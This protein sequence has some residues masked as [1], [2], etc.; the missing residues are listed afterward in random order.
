[1]TRHWKKHRIF[2]LNKLH[3]L[4]LDNNMV[5]WEKSYYNHTFIEDLKEHDNNE[6]FIDL[7]IN[8]SK[9]IDVE[10]LVNV[11]GI[12]FEDKEMYLNTYMSLVTES[13]FFQEDSDFHTGF[14]SE[15]IWKP[16]GHCQPFILA[17][18]SQS[19]KHIKESYGFKTFH[20]YI[21]ESYD[22]ELNDIK[23]IKMIETE[24]EKFSKKTKSE[25]ILFLENVKDICLHNQDLFLK[26]DE[27]NHTKNL[28]N[29]LTFL[30]GL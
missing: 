6:E 10:D 26:Y 16:V 20:P 22:N 11:S 24:I 1:M 9:Y 2:L 30:T 17:G 8:T 15:K 18:P 5:S 19:L 25:K 29:V 27:T 21:D 3:R 12:G 4:G 14:L 13:I 7:L 28:N 23:R